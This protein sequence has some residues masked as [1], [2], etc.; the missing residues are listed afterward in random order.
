MD[1]YG[2]LP[3]AADEVSTHSTGGTASSLI[4]EGW[5]TTKKSVANDS[6]SAGNTGATTAAVGATGASAGANSTAKPKTTANIMAFKPRQASATAAG[7]GKPSG[8]GGITIKPITNAANAG[9]NKQPLSGIAAAPIIVVTTTSASIKSETKEVGNQNVNQNTSSVDVMADAMDYDTTGGAT[10]SGGPHTSF[11][12]PNPYDPAKPNDYLRYCEER[13]ERNRLAKLEEDNR[14]QMLTAEKQRAERE[15]VRAEAVMSGDIEKIQSTMITATGAGRGR[16]RGSMM[17]NLPAWMTQGM[18]SSSEGSGSNEASPIVKEEPTSCSSSDRPSSPDNNYYS[19]S[20]GTKRS[21]EVFE[22]VE[23]VGKSNA[24][25]GTSLMARM[26]YVAGEG[27]GREGRGITRAIEHR[28]TGV[29]QG[30]MVMDDC[31]KERLDSNYNRS[32]SS[33]SSSSAPAPKRRQGAFSNPSCVVLLK[34]MTT[35]EEVDDSLGAET[36]QECSKYGTVLDCVI[37]PVPPQVAAPPEERVRI[38]VL[39][40]SQGGAI[41]AFRD[42]NGR[43]FG[44]RQI[45]ASFFDEDKF[46]RRDLDPQPGEW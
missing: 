5:S 17:S 35:V 3:P 40:E 8:S 13:L 2:D 7:S 12:V 37:R 15:K 20:A 19:G 43:Y 16:G 27:L 10:R 21:A 45:S 36:K 42:L 44:G 33:S 30:Q 41:K 34:N 26:G 1:L 31:D 4:G 32:A 6:G 39:F 29:G 14:Q 25:V 9:I 28:N 24:D 11:D 22:D 23:P 38:F 18:S 46:S